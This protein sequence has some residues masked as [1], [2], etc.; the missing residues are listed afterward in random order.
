MSK[1]GVQDGVTINVVAGADVTAGTVLEGAAG[2]G[3]WTQ[4][5]LSGAT[6]AVLIEGVVELAKETGVVFTALDALF[7]D[8]VNDRLDKTGTNIPAGLA[9]A[10]AASGDTVARVKLNAGA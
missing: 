1:V 5:T 7:W 9:A 3:V 2:I 6:G 8:A 4:D 10:P